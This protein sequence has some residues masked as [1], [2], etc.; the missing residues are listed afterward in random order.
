MQ[1][2]VVPDLRL[3]CPLAI[4]LQLRGEEEDRRARKYIRLPRLLFLIWRINRAGETNSQCND[5]VPLAQ[6]GKN[7]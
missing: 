6:G 7:N 1:L 4:C 3:P 5:V 2:F